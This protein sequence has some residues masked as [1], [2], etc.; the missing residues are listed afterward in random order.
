MSNQT[1]CNPRTLEA[2]KASSF[3]PPMC[4]SSPPRSTSR[5][6]RLFHILYRS[7]INVVP[8]VLGPVKL[9][10]TS[11]KS[12]QR[13][14][15]GSEHCPRSWRSAAPFQVPATASVQSLLA[16]ACVSIGFHAWPEGVGRRP[17][18]H[19]QRN[20]MHSVESHQHG[21]SGAL[22]TWTFGTPSSSQT[23]HRVSQWPDPAIPSAAS[24]QAKL[25]QSCRT[26]PLFALL[27]LFQRE[28]CLPPG[29]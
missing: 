29:L 4:E 17:E 16:D 28:S 21:H 20:S 1:Y 2:L 8:L 25:N 27:R 7:Y 9:P 23:A 11:F 15:K 3:Q 24:L 13:P 19:I 22:M 14:L 26:P 12:I 18:M 10:D 5:T 6:R